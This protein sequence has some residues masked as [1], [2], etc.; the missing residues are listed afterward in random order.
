M[1]TFAPARGGSLRDALRPGRGFEHEPVDGA[2]RASRRTAQNAATFSRTELHHDALWQD[3]AGGH[4][5]FRRVRSGSGQDRRKD[6]RSA[7]AAQ[8]EAASQLRSALRL[9]G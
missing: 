3:A 5:Q 4:E 1:D 9:G 8:E 7:S 2:E 6:G